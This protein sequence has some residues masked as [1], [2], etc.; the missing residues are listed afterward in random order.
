MIKIVC[1]RRGVVN[2][3]DTVRVFFTA[4]SIVDGELTLWGQL[5]DID[6]PFHEFDRL[7]DENIQIAGDEAGV[8]T[9]SEVQ[10]LK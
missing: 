7:I 2:E 4:T 6:D 1:A 5:I 3:G 9:E 10:S 8:C